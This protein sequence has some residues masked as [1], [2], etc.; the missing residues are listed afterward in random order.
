[1]PFGLIAMQ[2]FGIP[3]EVP[4]CAKGVQPVHR[5]FRDVNAHTVIEP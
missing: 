1:M 3:R 2:A 4:P 5:H